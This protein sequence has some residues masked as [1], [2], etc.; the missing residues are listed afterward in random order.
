MCET[1]KLYEQNSHLC[2]FDAVVL[3]CTPQEDRY[4]VVLDR[5]AF[6]PLGGGQPADIGQLG[7]ARVMDVRNQAGRIVH[8]T[9]TQLVP[10]ELVHG[11]IDWPHRRTLMQQH[12]GEH[13][14]SGLIHAR[15]GYD[16]TGF[17]MGA[18]STVIDFSGPISA[19]QLQEI[20]CA[21]NEVIYQNLPVLTQV[22]PEG[23][24]AKM[25]YRSKIPLHGRVRIVSI[26]GVDQCACCGTHVKHTGEIGLIRL[27]APQKHKGGTRFQLLCGDKALRDYQQKGAQ[28]AGLSA[29]LSARPEEVLTAATHLREQYEVQRQQVNA[30]TL[31]LLRQQA[32]QIV[33]HAPLLCCVTQGLTPVQVRQYCLMLCEKA[34]QVL[35]VNGTDEAGYQYAW[36]SLKQDARPLHQIWTAQCGAKG[37]GTQEL[38][39]GKCACTRT[40]IEQ[41]LLA[42]QV[43]I[44]WVV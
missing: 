31:Q 25:Q 37:G 16:N 13:I 2:A 15:F 32:E 12:S 42:L 20:E 1:V 33:V 39:Q 18:A 11:E 4:A 29:L 7:T 6:Y 44:Q 40:Q 19:E 41:A 43:Q 23:E 14:V 3:S 30:L 17:H 21:A 36:G 5:T 34:S 28:I 22:P 24:R 27:F 38:L 8:L 9:D 26:P 10:G 35:V